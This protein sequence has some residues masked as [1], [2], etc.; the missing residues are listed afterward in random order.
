MQ[1]ESPDA[2]RLV[3]ILVLTAARLVAQDATPPFVVGVWGPGE[4]ILPF[5]DFDGLASS[6]PFRR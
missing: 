2:K 6:T 5:A 4:A 1:P 3:V